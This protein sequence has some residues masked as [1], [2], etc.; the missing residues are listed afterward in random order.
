[1]TVTFTPRAKQK[2]DLLL[3]EGEMSTPE[4]RLMSGCAGCGGL[5]VGMTINN[6]R[7]DDDKVIGVDGVSVV[8]GESSEQYISD[9]L[10]DYE[11]NEY[12][13]NF[14]ISNEYGSSVCFI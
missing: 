12:G 9:T 11:D 13:G 2:V 6:Q 4:I 7:Q 1:M 10:V 3:Q 14:I 8:I 5:S